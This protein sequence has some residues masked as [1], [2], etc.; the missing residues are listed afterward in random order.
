MAHPGLIAPTVN[1]KPRDVLLPEGGSRK[2][3]Q[4]PLRMSAIARA[5][6]AGGLLAPSAQIQ[7]D[8]D[9]PAGGRL[10]V[11]ARSYDRPLVAFTAPGTPATGADFGVSSALNWVAFIAP[12]GL[13]MGSVLPSD[14][15]GT[16]APARIRVRLPAAGA[17]LNAL[18]G[19]DRNQAAQKVWRRPVP[20]FT[21]HA[22]FTI[23]VGDREV[24][25][26]GPMT[27]ASEPVM[28]MVDLAGAQEFDLQVQTGE[29][30]PYFAWAAW[31]EAVAT[32][33]DGRSLRLSAMPITEPEVRW[34]Q[35]DVVI[36]WGFARECPVQVGRI[37][38][39][40]G[41]LGPITTPDAQVVVTGPDA[42]QA[43]AAPA[44]CRRSIV[45]P[46]QYRE[47]DRGPDRTMVTVT[48]GKQV[49][50]F[51]PQ[52]LAQGPILLHDLS[53]GITDRAGGVSIENHLRQL[54]KQGAR[55]IR[56]RVRTAP[57]HSW[58]EDLRALRGP[59]F[60]PPPLRIN[61]REG[62][63]PF[64]EPVMRV[65]VPDRFLS[66]L[67]RVG[68]W[69]I[70][71]QFTRIHREDLTQFGKVAGTKSSIPY[72]GNLRILK[73]VQ[74][75]RGCWLP[76]GVWQPLSVEVD[77]IVQALDYLGLHQVASDCLD[78]W[79]ENQK[80]DGALALDTDAERAHALG[81]LS[82]PWVMAEHYRLSGDR[83]WLVRQKS[84]LQAAVDWI[85]R[86]RRA[87]LADTLTSE[88][89]ERIRRGERPHPGLQAPLAAGDG[90]GRAFIF[91]D[92][93]GYQSV[94]LM[95]DALAE[96]D[97]SLGRTLAA[98][99]DAYREVLLPVVE[100]A[101][102]AAPVMLAHDGLYRRYLP[103]GFADRGPLSL[104]EPAGSNMHRHCGSYL[105]DFV[106]PAIGIECL[107]RSRALPLDHLW[108]DEV[109]DLYEDRF[110]Y[111]HP[112]YHVRRPGFRPERD[113]ECLGG[114]CYQSPWERLP[115]YYLQADDIPNFLRAWQRR[116]VADMYFV[117][118]PFGDATCEDYM[119]KEHTWFNVYDKQ[120]NRG[121]FLSNFRNLLVMEQGQ[122]LW[123]ARATPRAWL[124]QGKKISVKNAPTYFGTVAYEIFSDVDN[125]K[126]SVTVEMPAR[127]APKEVVVRL[128]HPKTA[129][130]KGVTV[131]GPSAPSAGSGQA[132]SG[133]AKP[134]TEF[135]KDKETI[136]LKGLTGQVA[137]TAQY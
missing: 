106:V 81:Q 52:D 27:L 6:P 60:E 131:N 85:I 114:W 43:A 20:P 117:G 65:E 49:C 80:P 36:A 100:A 136:T 18:I 53:L 116:S 61:E 48:L 59:G 30:M 37:T 35:R 2:E 137:V 128:R 112:W 15:I 82:L 64:F 84:R 19:L 93:F 67:W 123:L 130:I 68:G 24:F 16:L 79:L 132:G 71:R 135:D 34:R 86:R 87:T 96:I 129:P 25:N 125:G 41:T 133:E 46:I 72:T 121:A 103:Q 94:R 62:W 45:V 32:L 44:G 98:E 55:T 56:Q 10:E 23:T 28:A 9:I 4:L 113:W 3:K 8:Q 63:P 83:D 74:D 7:R 102:A 17:T 107:L 57:E 95:A 21:G 134:W 126:I 66:H 42:W 109:F 12:T 69:G 40:G 50:T 120:H 89:R 105:G 97:A 88:D 111:D 58:E 1:D 99:A 101:V 38:I 51:L 118:D 14:G 11:L 108:I 78:L 75:P 13:A 26:S 73:D 115:E 90:G 124:E 54:Q 76:T 92:V 29:E 31:G 110:I 5:T 70:V 39:S 119:F 91:A 104:I 127:K 33:A 77:R 122:T 47:T 22:V